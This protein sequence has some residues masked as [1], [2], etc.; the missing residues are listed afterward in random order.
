[1]PTPEEEQLSANIEL[2][3]TIQL[4]GMD[5][6]QKM[7]LNNSIVDIRKEYE[8]ARKKAKEESADAAL[9]KRYKDVADSIAK[10]VPSLV[11]GLYAAV[12]AFEKR[13]YITGTAALMDI[14][15]SVIPVFTA[16]L[17]ATG[18]AGVLVGALFSLVG[19]I[20]SFFAPKQPSLEEKIQKM[21]DHQQSETQVI[22]LGGF[23]HSVSSY[24]YSLRTK[25]MG[26]HK[27]GKPV[28]LAGTV[29]LTPGSKTVTGTATTFTKKAVAGHWL[30][31]DSD[32]SG[33]VYKIDVIA[34]DVSLTLTTAYDGAPATASAL[35][36]LIRTTKKRSI[37]DILEMP[38]KTEDDAD[39]FL[40]EM[41]ALK[42]GLKEDKGKLDV[43]VFKN[44]EAS[45]YLERAENQKKEGW[46]EVLG[47]WCQ[48]Y[49]D[50]LSANMMLSCL[51]NPKTLDRRIKET[52]VTND[53]SPLVKAVR[54]E[55]HNAL[56][57][58]KALL[59]HLYNSWEAD[60]K[61][62]L[63]VAEKITP[64]ARERGLYAHV[65]YYTGM[66]HNILYVA[67]GNGSKD[68]LKW[69]YKKNTAWM[70]G[71][72]IHLPKA[73]KDSFTPK[74]ELLVCEQNPNRIGCHTLDSITGHLSDGAPVIEARYN[75][76]ERFLDVSAMAINEGQ[77]GIDFSTH[78]LTLVSLAIED[79][80][81][82]Y[83]VNLYTLDKSNKSA[84]VDWQPT[85]AGTRDIRGLYLP[86]TPLPDDPDAGALADAN[87]NPPGPP[88]VSGKTNVI[89]GGVRKANHLWVLAWNSW[90]TVEGPQHWTSYNGIEIDPYYVWLFGKGGI[91]CA[92]HASMIKCRQG[93]IKAP[94]WIYHDFDKQFKAPEVRSLYPC[95]D[96]TLLVAMLDEI[97]TADYKIDRSKG[98]ILTSSWVKRGGKAKQVIKMP[99]PCW[100]V[101]ESLKAN[102]QSE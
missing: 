42:W 51:A 12:G 18:P 10:A 79:N 40:G 6:Y 91:A 31:F 90:A 21:L 100:S 56:I 76:G 41:A 14:C 52:Q 99:I 70:S 74:Y 58:L 44:W 101:L 13:D 72:S 2:L 54:K 47:V 53:Q 24:T 45:A 61:E 50:L 94:T 23:A 37:D 93:K 39:D 69:D 7:M 83:Y 88:L 97:Y 27:M 19:Q 3:L 43:P 32:T 33:T 71:I 85:I 55:C 38:L 77:I 20:L 67:P 5:G 64:A 62:M 28:A 46:P 9:A 16:A 34:S 25:S 17:S 68:S 26:E 4:E 57:K 63:K 65:G 35:K 102:L 81:P 98:H 66:A 36:Q 49:I 86:P 11:K 48:T 60:Y 22:A 29:R 95:V 73:Q 30:T 82:N 80:G 59:R 87:A 92:T 15:A 8:D 89:Y 84:R 75:G 78:P 96:G 1:M